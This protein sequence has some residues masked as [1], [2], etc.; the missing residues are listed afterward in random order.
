LFKE[1]HT[2]TAIHHRLEELSAAIYLFLTISYA[3]IGNSYG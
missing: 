3:N 1:S 2:K